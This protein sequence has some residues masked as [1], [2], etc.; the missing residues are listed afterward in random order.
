VRFHGA[1]GGVCEDFT[2]TFAAVGERAEVERPIGVTGAQGG[3]GVGARGGGGEGVFEFV[4]G[5]EDT[6]GRRVG[7][8]VSRADS[9][10]D[11]RAGS[12]RWRSP[13]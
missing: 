7:I 1:A 3:G 11:K 4:E 8:A 6:H 12:A 9:S 10:N 13:L 5:E 2:E